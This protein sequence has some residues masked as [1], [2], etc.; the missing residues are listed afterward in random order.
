M[1]APLRRSSRLPRGAVEGSAGLTPKRHRAAL[2]VLPRVVVMPFRVSSLVNVI[3]ALGL[4]SATAAAH[5]IENT[6]DGIH[7]FQ[8]FDNN[9][10]QAQAKADAMRYVAVW[11][12]GEPAAWHAGNAGINTSAYIPFARDPLPRGLAFWKK[13]HPDWVVY[14][15][16]R[17]TPAYEGGQKRYIPLDISNPAVRAWQMTTYGG[18]A[19]QQG[20]DA[21]AA[22]NLTLYD[23]HA[24]GVFVNGS[25]VRK[26]SGA[27][28]NDAPWTDAVIGWVTYAHRYLHGLARPLGLVAN[29]SPSY[30]PV[31]D[32]ATTRIVDQLDIVLDEAGFSQFGS[33]YTT[34]SSWLN[35]VAWMGYTQRRG[36]AYLVIDEWPTVGVSQLEWSIAS[37]L[38]GKADAAA[39]FVSGIQQ[40]GSEQW[41]PEY[42]AA[43]GRACGALYA[44]QNVYFR[45]FGGG[46][47]VVN[48]SASAT[49]TVTLPRPSYQDLEGKTVTSPLTMTPHTGYALVTSNGCH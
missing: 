40:Y 6:G 26:F 16:D 11:G 42:G 12:S 46:L 8:V 48:P 17:K 45:R 13:F 4:A 34:D 1:T 30:A 18:Q 33:G 41:H 15:C 23:F 7:A 19:E 31:G 21:L 5:P 37:Y 35:L 10:P 39:I 44:A 20:F 9:I 38:A 29:F 24:C 3:A 27:G 2:P 14:R 22:D 28:S 32:P 36:G 47:A 25:W 43:I 49:Y